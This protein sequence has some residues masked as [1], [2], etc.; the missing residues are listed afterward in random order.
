MW[1]ELVDTIREKSKEGR[2]LS[3]AE[4]AVGITALV[5]CP[6]KWELSKTYDVEPTA[7][8]ID[9]GFVWERQVKSALREL[10]GESFQEEKDLIYEIDG[11]LIHGHLDCFIEL[12]DEVIGI[13]LKAPKYILLKDIPQFIKD[14]LYEDEGLVIHN[15]VYLTQ[16]K[17]Q[18][19]IIGRLYPHK[20]VR[21]YLFYK[22]L[23]KHKSWSQKLYV[24]SEVKESITEEELKELVRRFHED[25]SPRYPNECTSYCVFYREGL[26]EGR[27]YRLEEEKPQESAF[28]L[29]RY[30]RT[31]ETELKQVETLLKKAVKGTLKIGGRE[32]GWVKREVVSFDVEKLLKK[33]G[34]KAHEYVYVKPSKKEEILNTFGDEVVKE[35]REEVIWKL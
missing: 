15:S 31:L 25:K 7:V 34:D 29:L 16:A 17:I 19:F 2:E 26:C 3:Y 23:A 11:T 4:G 24:L 14:G 21:Q 10:Y 28:E 18:R 32:L 35:K 12:E 22:S 20:Q 5:H 33:A 1:K 6:L 30:Y 9:D 8:E 13:E 27:E